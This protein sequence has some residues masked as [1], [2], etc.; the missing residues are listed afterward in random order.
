MNI[1]KYFIYFIIYSFFGWL[2]EVID[3]LFQY[4]KFVNRGFLIGPL[5]TIYGYG[6]LAIITLI[7]KNTSD[8]LGVFLKS[9][10][11]CS[12]LEYLTSYCM[13]KLFKAKW[14]DYSTKKFN[15]NGRICLNTMIPFGILG[16][17]I[18]YIVHPF[19]IYIVDLIP[20]KALNIIAIIIFIMFLI[21]NIISFYVTLKIKSKI[22]DTNKDNTE[23]VR[24]EVLKWISEK[25]VL[26]NRIKNSYP[27]IF[28]NLKENIES[29]LK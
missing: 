8:I 12:I 11:I 20:I 21:D 17:L 23:Y 3:K 29:I 2:L 22:H 13:E 15:I 10:F 26:Y 14:W 28:A 5:C 6:T 1:A 7:G 16:C 18:V 19:V 25:S 9:I 27:S 4:K 24:K